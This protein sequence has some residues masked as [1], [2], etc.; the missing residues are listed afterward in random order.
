MEK[1]TFC[2]QRINAAKFAARNAGRKAADGQ[3][4]TACQ[5]ACPAKAI[6][7]GNINDPDSLVAR[8]RASP[9]IYFV[10]EQLNVKPSV[11][12][13]AKIRNRIEDEV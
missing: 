7:F 1:C 3:I 10:L 8:E 12:Y 2:V 13:K 6:I 5:Q 4:Q 11:G 9:L